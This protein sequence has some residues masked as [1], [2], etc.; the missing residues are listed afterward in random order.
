M[1][2]RCYLHSF[3]TVPL[4][5]C[6]ALSIS[7]MYTIYTRTGCEKLPADNDAKAKCQSSIK[8]EF[9]FNIKVQTLHHREFGQTFQSFVT[10][11]LGA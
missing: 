6:G 5:K 3:Y 8:T 4:Y 1:V 10:I 9:S 2:R 11:S 7:E